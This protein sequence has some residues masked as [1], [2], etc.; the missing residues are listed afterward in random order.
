VRVVVAEDVML[1]REGIVRVLRDAGFQVVG[2]AE[3][4][5]GLLRSVALERPEAVVVDIR[6]PPTHT[7]EGLVAAQRIRTE[8]P[9][10]AVLLLSQYVEPSYAMRLIQDHPERV[11]YLLKERIFDAAILVDALRRIT[12]GECVIDPTIVSRLVGRQRRK[13]PLSGLTDREREV[14]GLVAEGLSNLAIANR[15]FVTERTIEAHT[16]QVFEKLGLEADPGSNRRVLAVLA[17]L[18]SP[19]A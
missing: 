19:V 2:E 9:D 16:K 3:D 11:G 7:D 15:L 18:R 1:T 10:I 4:L 13:D 8:H 5:N 14:L 12:E 17:F 6:M